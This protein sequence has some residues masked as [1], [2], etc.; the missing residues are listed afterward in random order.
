[1]E[2]NKGVS[3]IKKF[4]KY[5][6]FIFMFVFFGAVFNVVQTKAIEISI[7]SQ[8]KTYTVKYDYYNQLTVQY[9]FNNGSYVGVDL[10]GA[11]SNGSCSLKIPTLPKPEANK[12]YSD[13][14]KTGLVNFKVK[15]EDEGY[16]WFGEEKTASADIDYDNSAPSVSSIQIAR[17]DT[18]KSN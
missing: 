7:N 4:L 10:S 11:C 18:S 1:M 9:S 17:N 15:A 8:A 5:I 14:S 16:L 12:S 13:T 6:S 2:I 3:K